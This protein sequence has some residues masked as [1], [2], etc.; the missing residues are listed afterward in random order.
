MTQEQHL[1][2]SFVIFNNVK[3]FFT[4]SQNVNAKLNSLNYLIQMK[5]PFNNNKFI[6]ESIKFFFELFNQFSKKENEEEIE[7]KK[8]ENKKILNKKEKKNKIMN[9]LKKE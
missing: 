4:Q 6:E 3:T 9:R 7:N 5:I 2:M 1:K 8:Y